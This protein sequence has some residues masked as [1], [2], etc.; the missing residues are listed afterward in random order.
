MSSADEKTEGT[1]GADDSPEDLQVVG[2]GTG[3]EGCGDKG[4]EDDRDR[5]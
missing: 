1:G 2:I 4:E 3:G 5:W